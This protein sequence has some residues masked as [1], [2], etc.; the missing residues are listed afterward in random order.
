[1]NKAGKTVKILIYAPRIHLNFRPLINQLTIL[2][3]DITIAYSYS[4]KFDYQYS[5]IVQIDNS[6]MESFINKFIRI[7]IR[8]KIRITLPSIEK[9]NQLIKDINP[10]VIIIKTRLLFFLLLA[11]YKPKKSKDYILL[12]QDPIYSCSESVIQKLRFLTIKILRIRNLSPNLSSGE[13]SSWEL[14]KYR[15]KSCKYSYWIPFLFEVKNTNPKVLKSKESLKLLVVSRYSPFKRIE[16]VIEALN[17]LRSKLNVELIIAG[18]LTDSNYFKNIKE[19]VRKLKLSNIV[20][21]HTDLS[22]KELETLYNDSHIFVHPSHFDPA[23]IA[24]A[25]ALSWGMPILL[26]NEA[27]LSYSIKNGIN[28]HIIDFK[29]IESVSHIIDNY[30][31]NPSLI[32]FQ[33]SKS[34][35]ISY[36]LYSI[37]WLNKFIND[38]LN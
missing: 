25:E 29:D 22:D 11:L 26:S 19:L 30:M 6:N 1:M 27:G 31:S 37:E 35:E 13:Y 23:P 3:H 36:D 12:H 28:G 38:F 14:E 9:F 5:K 10:D 32:E 34:I 18:N 16:L 4:S 7:I 8:K 24:V 33:S 20:S 21:F 2:G 17:N 15:K